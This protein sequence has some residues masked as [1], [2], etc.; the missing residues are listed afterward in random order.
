MQRQNPRYLS[1]AKPVS[2]KGQL[3]RRSRFSPSHMTIRF[4]CLLGAF[5]LLVSGLSAQTDS[6]VANPNPI[7]VT[8]GSGIGVTTISFDAPGVNY[9]Q[10]YVGVTLFCAGG[11]SGSCLTGKWVT[12]GSVFTLKNGS[13][14]ATLASVTV[15]VVSEPETVSTPSVPTGPISGTTGT[16]YSYSTGGSTSSYGNSVQ[17]FFNWGDG[18]NS[19]WLATG[20]TS[21]SHSW[22]TAGTYNITAQARSAPHTS[23]VSTVSG[24]LGVAVSAS[25]THGKEYIR[26]NGRVIAIE[27]H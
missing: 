24:S 11:A 18:S 16:G 17:Y 10:V 6:I 22:T 14:G 1:L 7:L 27:N 12:N 2:P 13:T 4:L 21:A 8:D 19:G 15:Q 3:D 26:L 9:T 23:I 5:L 20:T 25:T